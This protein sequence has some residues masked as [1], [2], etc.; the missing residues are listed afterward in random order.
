[1]LN[2][3]NGF[4]WDDANREKNWKKHKVSYLEAEQIFFN[5]PVYVFKDDKHSENESRW[6]CLGK[7]NQAR[8]LFVVF[9]VRN[10]KIRVISARDMHKKEREIYAKKK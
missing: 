3:V 5:Q 7:T 9:T 2:K 1:M 8:K 10:S 4:D 6:Y